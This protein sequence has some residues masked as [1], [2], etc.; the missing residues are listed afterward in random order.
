MEQEKQT[1][2]VAVCEK[3]RKCF[4]DIFLQHPEVKC[5]ATAIVWNGNLNDA[6]ILH[7]V[8]L[9][10]D[11]GQVQT[12]DAIIGSISQ[13]TRMLELQLNRGADFAQFLREQI[14]LLGTELIEKHEKESKTSSEKNG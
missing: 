5:L 1:F 11:G 4:M 14:Q 2:D 3:L 10:S 8:W 13:T 7:G 9:N 6:N 12:A